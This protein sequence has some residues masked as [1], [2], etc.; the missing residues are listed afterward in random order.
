MTLSKLLDRVE[1]ETLP[2]DTEIKY[3]TSDSRKAGPGTLFVCI[4]GLKTDGHDY[5]RKAVQN[6]AAAIVCEHDLG[7]ENQVIT[8]D[9]HKAWGTISSNFFGRPSEKLKL[10]GI[11]GTNGKTTITY[12]IKHILE[13]S[14]KKTGLIGTIHNEI[15]DMVIPAK[16]T[17]PDPYQLHALL[18]R[19]QKAGCEYVVMEV[20]SHALDQKRV[21]GCKFDVGVFTNLTQDHLDYHGTME[22]YY[23]AKKK[24]FDISK[25]AVI[26]LDDKAGIRLYDEITCEKTGFSCENS[27]GGFMAHGIKSSRHGAAYAL[28]FDGG[29]YKFKITMPGMFSVYNALAATAACNVLGISIEEIRES[30]EDMKGVPG[31]IEIL[32]TNTPYTVIRDYAHAADGIEKVLKAVKEFAEKRVVILFGCAGNR[33]RSKRPVMAEKAAQY[34]DFCIL[35]TDN[36]RDEDPLKI[37]EDAK[38]GFKKYA[39]PYKII[40]DRYKAI[41]WALDFMEEDDILILAGKGHEDYQVLDYG[42]IFFDE[43]VI[44]KELLD[45]KKKD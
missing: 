32:E 3:I 10:I 44:V 30:L 12:L 9:T 18:S 23:L 45:K 1:Y 26:N 37:I 20:S 40:P 8:P 39:T 36:P 17:T 25:A 28:L 14:G 27:S 15:G 29:L 22:E 4:K 5:A 11:T 38:A 2:K 43:K 24:L 7:L 41:S 21:E 16:H 42:T 31:R 6:G 13:K 19:M 35:T 33:D 34:A